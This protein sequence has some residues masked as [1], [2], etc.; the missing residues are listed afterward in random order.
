MAI[1]GILLDFDGLI[2]E[3]EGPI[4]RSWQE[5]YQSYGRELPFVAF[6]A[7]IGTAENTIDLLALLEEQLGQTL[8]R[9]EVAPRRRARETELVAAEPV[10]PGVREILASAQAL[11]LKRA[12]VSSSSRRWVE[13]HLSRLG[14]GGEFDRLITG[15]DVQPTKPDPAL[16]RVAL[17]TLDLRPEQALA[18]EDSRH[19]FLAARGAGIFCVVVPTALTRRIPL[20]EADLRVESLAEVDLEELIERIRR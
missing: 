17:Q 14:L 18:F 10:M 8:P 1:K 16:Y 20:D 13:G 11:G 2:L 9:E 7:T 15:S 6:A 5:L 19:G 3:T 12:V 4:F